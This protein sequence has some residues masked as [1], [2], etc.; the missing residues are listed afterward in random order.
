MR[1]EYCDNPVPSGATRCPSCGATVSVVEGQQTLQVAQTQA[2]QQ[3]L[4]APM[5]SPCANM[6]GGVRLLTAKNKWVYIILGFFL[7]EFGIHNFYTGY[8]GRGIVKL[9]ITTLS[10]GF[11]CCFSW[12]WAIVEICTVR[13]D[14]RG[15]PFTA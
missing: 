12:I 13:I 3:I 11:L 15:V 8:I 1:C 5:S 2:T 4:H 14:S 7:G 10:F 6:Y 9:L